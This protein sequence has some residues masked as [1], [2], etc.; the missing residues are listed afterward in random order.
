M[1][2]ICFEGSEGVGKTTQ[3]TNLYNYLIQS[4]KTVLLTKEPGSSHLPITLELRKFILDSKYET[5]PQLLVQELTLLLAVSDNSLFSSD[6]RDWLSNSLFLIKSHNRITLEAR[7]LIIQ[8][9][10]SIHLE[11]LVKSSIHFDY[12][13]QDRGILSGLA[14]GE[15]SGL[16][17]QFMSWLNNQSTQKTFKKNQFEIYDKII[18]LEGNVSA[19]LNRATQ[20][21]KEFDKGDVIESRGSNYLEKVDKAFKSLKN[22]F[23]TSTINV[24]SKSILEVFE[25][26]K[27]LI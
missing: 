9:V 8:A 10:R 5:N 2:Y 16:D 23:N 24:D 26:I 25:E 15:A 19:G 12:V 6:S 21:K 22:N 20:A 3:I 7:E 11:K 13:I 17:F 14:Y 4:G 1:V 27:G 18:L